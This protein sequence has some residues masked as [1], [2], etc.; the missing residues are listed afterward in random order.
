MKMKNK[1]T[2]AKMLSIMTFMAFLATVCTL[3]AQDGDADLAQELSNPI[4]DLITVP[5]QMNFDDNIGPLD[6]GW[7]LQTNIQPVIPFYMN[8]LSTCYWIK[9]ALLWLSACSSLWDV[10][11]FYFDQRRPLCG[12]WQLLLSPR[13]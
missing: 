1:G 8:T 5:V 9:P 13:Y 3:Q 10:Y 6:D 4:A 12:L 7:K 11:G 2:K